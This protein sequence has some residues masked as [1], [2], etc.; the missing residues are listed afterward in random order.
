MSFILL[1]QAASLH[2][3]EPA[4]TGWNAELAT[5]EAIRLH[6]LDIPRCKACHLVK[7]EFSSLAEVAN[8]IQSRDVHKDFLLE[9]SASSEKFIDGL[10]VLGSRVFAIQITLSPIHLHE[11]TYN[12]FRS[13][14]Y[15]Q[16]VPPGI[17]IEW[18]ILWVRPASRASAQFDQP[19]WTCSF[20]Y[21]RS[22]AVQPADLVLNQLVLNFG[23][24]HSVLEPLDQIAVCDVI[25]F[26]SDVFVVL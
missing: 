5:L 7:K 13:Q 1:G 12:F 11:H 21:T 9:P 15:L 25:F 20:P 4:L 24:V 16:C 17:N 2:S 23:Q 26:V 22:L 10:I 8:I 18:H 14:L 3:A 19:T 6:G